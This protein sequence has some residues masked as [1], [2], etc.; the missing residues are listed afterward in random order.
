[1]KH[2]IL[3]AYDACWLEEIKDDVLNF[4]HK[5]AKEMLAHLLTEFIKLTNQEKLAKL[6]ETEFPWLAEE[7]VS[8]YFNKLDKEQERL[9]KMVIK[10]DNTQKV[11]QAVDDMYN[12]SLFN[13]K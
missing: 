8:I 2:L 6:K 13:E 7:D 3:T 5:T 9:K 10:W 1:M 12:I 4:T 11:T